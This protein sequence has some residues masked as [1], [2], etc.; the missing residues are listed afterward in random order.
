MTAAED[1]AR[2]DVVVNVDALWGAEPRWY[3]IGDVSLGDRGISQ[4]V[5]F[6]AIAGVVL[7]WAAGALPLFAVG[8]WPGGVLLAVLV[9]MAGFVKPNGLRVHVFAPAAIAH[10]AASRHLLGFMA[11]GDPRRPWRPGALVLEADGSAPAFADLVYEGPG[12]VVRHRP[13]RRLRAPRTL[14]DRLRRRPAAQ[15]LI[16]R[17]DLPRLPEPRVLAVPAGARLIVRSTSAQ[18]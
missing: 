8:W 4:A 11:I 2:V 9:T 6:Y 13:A 14:T 16:A 3:R 15:M 12:L 17:T 5:V 18:R 7:A 10:L 1:N